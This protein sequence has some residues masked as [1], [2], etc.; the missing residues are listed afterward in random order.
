MTGLSD[1][2]QYLIEQR[3]AFCAGNL[4]TI[5]QGPELSGM[6]KILRHLDLVVPSVDSHFHVGSHVK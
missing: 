1:S 4:A 6:P 5:L 3:C 2:F